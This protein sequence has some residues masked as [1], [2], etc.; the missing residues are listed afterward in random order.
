MEA[1]GKC[2]PGRGQ[3]KDRLEF[4]A[5]DWGLSEQY[6]QQHRLEP[7]TLDV[8]KKEQKTKREKEEC[9]QR[10]TEVLYQ[11]KYYWLLTFKTIEWIMEP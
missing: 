4:K 11:V 3:D 9:V 2:T 10:P 1:S 5:K 7:L 6:G 8:W